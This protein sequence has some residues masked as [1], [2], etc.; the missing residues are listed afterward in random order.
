MTVVSR[1]F[2][3]V[4]P[5]AEFGLSL[6]AAVIGYFVGSH[7]FQD[8]V[9]QRSR[10]AEP[11]Q[12]LFR[13][14]GQYSQPEPLETPLYLL[15]Y[16]A[17][18]VLAWL[19]YG[20]W[21]RWQKRFWWIV[22]TSMAVSAVAGAAIVLRRLDGG[23]IETVLQYLTTRDPVHILWF[24]ATKRLLTAGIALVLALTV[25]LL[26]IR[27]K[28]FP[29]FAWV[30][31]HAESPWLKK[32]EPWFFAAIAIAIFHPNF[33]FDPHH[34]NYFLGAVNNA[35]HGK[36][37]LYGTT[38]LY[39]LLDVYFIQVVF[40]YF[41]PLNY[42]AAA[43]LI[44]AFFFAFF[45]GMYGFLKRWLD[46]RIFAMVGVAIL[47]AVLYFFQT[48][49]T[50]SAFFFPAMT[51]FRYGWYLPV[52]FG[53]FALERKYSAILREVL[54]G[55][56]ALGVFWVFDFGLYAAGAAF[57]ALAYAEWRRTGRWVRSAA[58]LAA[59]FVLY[60]VAIAGVI[61]AANI[62]AFGQSPN[63]ALAIRD[64]VPFL[65]WASLARL[66][67]VGAFTVLVFVYVLTGL[68]VF[69]RHRGGKA[70]D[71]SL[72]FL[73]AYGIL[74]LAYYIGEST[75]QVVYVVI[76]P[77]ILISFYFVRFPAT[78]GDV[79]WAERTFTALAYGFA[80]FA[81]VLFV[82]RAPIEF[83]G[84]DYT[85]VRESFVGFGWRGIS[86]YAEYLDAR[87]IRSRYPELTELAIISRYDTPVLIYAGAASFF[88]TPYLHGNTLFK[89]QML[90][91][92]RKVQLEKP[93]YVF[94]GR[95]RDDQI[96][97]FVARVVDRYEYRVSLRTVDVYQLRASLSAY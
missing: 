36:A 68:V 5:R 40:R 74:S 43:F 62:V 28:F 31:A 39:G 26:G 55:F 80:T 27:R 19:I 77:A 93:P 95:A 50:R 41:L 73:L 72:L 91:F 3:E 7:L 11:V 57:V 88:G 54:I 79:P 78:L 97:F 2:R 33:P 32:L 71:L 38:H 92:I 4:V 58:W 70:V 82:V 35:F 47:V 83:I 18:P 12:G 24:V 23:V 10:L 13:I 61:T 37:M 85:T 22:I 75:W 42:P 30:E 9:Y 16:V 46:S 45:A 65:A 90:K 52:L 84:R 64:A 87:D 63:W 59:R 8:F 56:A 81:L 20:S 17:I 67:F 34:Y 14:Y 6:A 89:S 51:P 94:V 66:P 53:L 44:A 49:P 76:A 21:R 1:F 96:D 86:T 29:F 60:G 48:S 15:G 69:A 25:F